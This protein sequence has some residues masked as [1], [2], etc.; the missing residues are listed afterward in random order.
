MT[1]KSY[2][3]KYTIMKPAMRPYNST[4]AAFFITVAPSVTTTALK[5]ASNGSKSARV[6]ALKIA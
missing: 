3:E 5:S 1:A 6:H 4:M 2:Q